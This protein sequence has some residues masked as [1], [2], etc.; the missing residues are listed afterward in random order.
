ML[1]DTTRTFSFGKFEFAR[2]RVGES[3]CVANSWVGEAF[4]RPGR[5]QD[6]FP[7][8]PEKNPAA[9][10]P[11]DLEPQPFEGEPVKEFFNKKR[12]IGVGCPCINATGGVFVTV[13]GRAMLGVVLLDIVKGGLFCGVG[14]GDGWVGL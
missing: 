7:T 13:V 4:F 8:A 3:A 5:K 12:F 1:L 2:V 11:L 14:G 6:I 10:L 9:D